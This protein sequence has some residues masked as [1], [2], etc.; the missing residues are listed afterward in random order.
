MFG[1]QMDLLGGVIV[2]DQTFWLVCA[3][4][5][6]VDNFRRLDRRQL[7]LAE[8]LNGQWSP[9][10]PLHG[11]RISGQALV[12]LNP[13]SPW[14][15]A[16][17]M[18]WLTEDAFAS[19][20]L[21]RSR[22]LL[23]IY[24]RRLME[25]RLLSALLF[26]VFFVAGPL[27][28][29]SLGLGSALILVLPFY[30]VALLLLVIK[31]IAERRVWRMTWSELNSLVFQCALCPGLFINICR[32]VSLGHVRVPGDVVA[33]ALAHG[34]PHSALAIE[35][36]LDL[37]RSD[38]TDHVELTAEDEHRIEVYKRWLKGAAGHG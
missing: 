35:R 17:R 24:R 16:V 33:Y 8:R 6:I 12:I 7:I 19:R 34:A 2:H 32:K 29:H 4:F 10:F 1:R 18:D 26:V 3:L 28:T 14:L 9:I 15:A 38:L 27:A 37:C 21:H 23:F 11:Y 5:Y 31:L 25:F 13:L 36:Q 22:R 30:V 20:D